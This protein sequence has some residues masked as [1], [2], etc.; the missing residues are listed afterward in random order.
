MQRFCDASGVIYF[1]KK[2]KVCYDKEV[3]IVEQISG[4]S[5]RLTSPINEDFIRDVSNL[6]M[7]IR[8]KRVPKGSY[9]VVACEKDC[10]SCKRTP[11]NEKYKRIITDDQCVI[12]LEDFQHQIAGK[13]TCG[14]FFHRQCMYYCF[15]PKSIETR[16]RLTREVV[17]SKEVERVCPICRCSFK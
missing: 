15:R 7:N 6:M 17:N 1:P 16:N 12:C 8:A 2:W 10:I 13:L 3:L 14:H 4:K 11:L 9:E 5:N